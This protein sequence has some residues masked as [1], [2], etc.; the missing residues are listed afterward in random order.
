M[1]FWSFLFWFTV[2]ILLFAILRYAAIGLIFVGVG[3]GVY[4]LIKSRKAWYEPRKNVL[5]K[6]FLKLIPHFV[7]LALGTEIMK[8]A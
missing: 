8:S 4:K 7:F 2:L 6:Y 5:T 1:N 3:F